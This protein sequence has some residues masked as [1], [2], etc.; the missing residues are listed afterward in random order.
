MV[1]LNSEQQIR[2][3]LRLFFHD[4]DVVELRCLE[5]Q[6]GNRRVTA[7]GY[8][9]DMDKLAHDAAAVDGLC[10]GI[11]VVMNRI[12]PA[13]LARRENKL[14]VNSFGK[15]LESTTADDIIRRTHFLID[16][17]AARPSGIS[18]T[19]KELDYAITKAIDIRAWLQRLGWP[20]GIMIMSG[21]GAQLVYDIDLPNDRET[22]DLVKAC[23]KGLDLVK[24]DE[25]AHVDV[26]VVDPSRIWKLPGTMACKGSNT[27]DRPHRRSYVIEA[28]PEHIVVTVE[29]LRELAKLAETLDTKPA[30][31][32]KCDYNG[33]KI[34]AANL[35]SRMGLRVLNSRRTSGGE[36]HKLDH[37]PWNS[38]HDGA[39]LVEYDNG[40][41]RVGC[42]HNSCGGPSNDR[43]KELL[44]QYLP[45]WRASKKEE[46]KPITGLLPASFNLTDAG[47]AERLV[48]KYGEKIRY[49]PQW[50]SWLIYD[51]Q[52]WK[53]DDNGEILD[54]ALS[55]LRDA[56]EEMVNGAHPLRDK[57]VKYLLE[58]EDIRNLKAMVQSAQYNRAV[59]VN[60][61]RL[62]RDQMLL[63][64]KNG[65]IDLRVGKMR[66]HDPG[67][68]ITMLAPVDYVEDA[69][70]PKFQEFLEKIFLA[71]EEMIG[72]VKRGKGYSAS[73]MT[74]E[75]C[76]FIQWG[77]GRNGKG[78][79][80]NV[81]M[82][83]L[84][85]YHKTAHADTLMARN[86]DNGIRNDL[87]RLKGARHVTASESKKSGVL[88]EAQV[89]WITGQDPILSRFL[90][91]EFFEYVP[92]FKIWLA[93]NH[94]PNIRGTDQAIWDRV[95]LIPFE[96]R[97][98][99]GEQV[100]DYY[101]LLFDE[102]ASG[103]LN[104]LIEG[105]LEWQK[106]GLGKSE[107]VEEATRE[108]RE[109][110]DRLAEFIEAN[111]EP[112]AT[113]NDSYLVKESVSRYELWC[114]ANGI[115]PMKKNSFIAAMKERGYKTTKGSGNVTYWVGLK[116]IPV[117][118]VTG[119]QGDNKKQVSEGGLETSVTRVTGT[120]E[121]VARIGEL[122][123]DDGMLK[124]RRQKLV[125]IV[126]EE[127]RE[128]GV[129]AAEERIFQKMALAGF[130]DRGAVLADLRLLMEVCELEEPNNA[131]YYQYTGGSV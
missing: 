71:D 20:M 112:G 96:Y 18:S 98:P 55:T 75:R 82:L 127:T 115:E 8:Y 50:G 80:N 99:E 53:R 73:G 6:Q 60:Q 90:N 116:V 35:I 103:I 56:T 36:I 42:P 97:F 111:F 29:Q 45:E 10:A 9:N 76:M 14:E 26:S 13:L 23:L 104:W 16:I 129:G 83:V 117:T 66:P 128:N 109:E 33:P 38:N 25:H 21:N 30:K 49:C 113:K 86:N 31:T 44:D 40:W 89:K 94:K 47:N 79:L 24:S 131:G 32:E 48:K 124:L 81:I 105:C 130:V 39:F 7:S 19:Q 1:I 74:G 22:D 5:L 120:P 52:R 101:R 123:G 68:L 28:D 34:D 85:D 54:L 77:E 41:V 102:E 110:M 118:P 43:T 37:C 3:A 95:K 126:I 93:T 58:S 51:G 15:K 4:G 27:A 17:D 114:S 88:D 70:C 67:D 46:E 57:T 64:V 61:D 121:T 108:Y 78:T 12:N 91:H 100:K 125:G 62:D 92:D 72:F 119:V 69:T 2:E 107:T 63:N 87:A 65:T 106:T 84:G 59:I 11:Y 122:S